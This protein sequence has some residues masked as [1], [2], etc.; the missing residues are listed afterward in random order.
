MI[1]NTARMTGDVTRQKFSTVSRRR[2]TY[3]CLPAHPTLPACASVL[4]KVSG[5]YSGAMAGA[6]RLTAFDVKYVAK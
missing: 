3:S 6:L 1:A 2:W 4:G 5:S